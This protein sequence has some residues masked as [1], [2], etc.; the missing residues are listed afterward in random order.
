MKKNII[1]KESHLLGTKYDDA[2]GY[3]IPILGEEYF[4]NIEDL[5]DLIKELGFDGAISTRELLKELGF[6]GADLNCSFST[7]KTININKPNCFGTKELKINSS[8]CKNCSF[9]EE[10]LKKRKKI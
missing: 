5:K 10:C 3:E 1:R 7:E 9:K 6:D 8:I 4:V 2:F